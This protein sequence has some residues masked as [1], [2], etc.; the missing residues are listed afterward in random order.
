MRNEV[1]G[2]LIYSENTYLKNL[3]SIQKV[4]IHSFIIFFFSSPSYIYIYSTPG[5]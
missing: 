3:L 2:E 4:S 5:Q 1:I